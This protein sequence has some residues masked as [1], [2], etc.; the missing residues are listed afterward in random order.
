MTWGFRILGIIVFA[1]GLLSCLKEPQWSLTPSISFSQI[2]KITKTSNDGF[3][4]KA[5][6]DSVVMSIHFQ[7][8]DGDLG[9]TQA[10]LKA[11]PTKYKDFR[12]FEVNVLLQKNGKFVPVTF[13]PSLGGLMNFKF[14]ADQK[15][16]PIEGTVDYST[17]F[18]Y[19][20]YKG[21][22]PLFTP[23]NDTLKFQIYIRDNALQ[24]SNVV[25]TDPIVI[26]QD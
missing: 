12:N 20:F 13:S 24:I 21:Y 1:V 14:K 17:Q 16:G 8:G 25:E 23:K 19:A 18:V 15:P 6:I 3:G 7:D 9:I 22:S 26:F 5:K 4:G 2:Q 11:N 10:D